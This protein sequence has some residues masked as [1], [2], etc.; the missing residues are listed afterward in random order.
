MYTGPDGG[1]TCAAGLAVRD[2]LWSERYPL[3]KFVE[4][5]DEEFEAELSHI[6]CDRF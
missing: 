3:E 2:I 4:D 1:L 6:R 5:M